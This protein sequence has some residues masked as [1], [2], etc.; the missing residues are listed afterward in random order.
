MHIFYLLRDGVVDGGFVVDGGEVGGG[1][2]A[3]ILINVN[4][5]ISIFS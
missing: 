1:V 2:V 4:K 3:I 5:I